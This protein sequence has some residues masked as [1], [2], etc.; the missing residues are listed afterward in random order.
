MLACTG[1][2]WVADEFSGQTWFF[3]KCN[4]HTRYL[5]EL[6]RPEQGVFLAGADYASGWAGMIDGAIES[7]LVI[8]RKVQEYLTS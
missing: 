3:Q 8:S 5:A 6:Q 4:H 1:H 2:D 7:G